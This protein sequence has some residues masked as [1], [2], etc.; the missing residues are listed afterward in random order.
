MT[1]P[2]SMD[3]RTRLVSAVEGGMT[4]RSAAKRVGVAASTEIKWVEQ[5][6]Q[7]GD[8][9]PRTQGGDHRSHRLETYAAG[10]LG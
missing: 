9:G 8:V 2:L 1:R 6:E 7:T 5:W 4:R 3:I 10:I